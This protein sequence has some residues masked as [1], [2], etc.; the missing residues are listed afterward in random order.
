MWEVDPETRSKVCRLARF[1]FREQRSLRRS[2]LLPFLARA[3]SHSYASS[4]KS[5][6]EEGVG[7]TDVVTAGLL[8]HN[9][10]KALFS[11]YAQVSN[12]N[13]TYTG[14]PQILYLH[15]PLLRRNPPRSRRTHLLRPLYLYG[16]L[17][18]E[19]DSPHATRR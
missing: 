6:R 14:I 2:G 1:A 11:P 9:G 15:L 5:R 13:R 7:T 18:T 10:Y 19:R 17:Q 12:S 3:N 8:H 16:C 4:T